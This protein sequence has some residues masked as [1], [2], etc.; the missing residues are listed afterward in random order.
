MLETEKIQL[1]VSDDLIEISDRM[2]INVVDI[3]LFLLVISAVAVALLGPVGVV[4]SVLFSIGY[5]A[6]RYMAWVMWQ[7]IEINLETNQITTTKM[8]FGKNMGSR[9]LSNR[10]K[11]KD[12]N[13]REFEQSGMQRAML[14]YDSH[15][16][17]NL[18]LLTHPKDIRLIKEEVFKRKVS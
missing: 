14:Q 10:F 6:F 9:V 13:L 5:I 1:K 11:M 3:L 17:H 8:I 4:Y 16:I 2:P 12:L 7:K 18:L 15:L